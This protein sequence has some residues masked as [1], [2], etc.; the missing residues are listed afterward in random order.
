MSRPIRFRAWDSK[1]KEWLTYF[2]L[3][4]S[5]G[6]VIQASHSSMKPMEGRVHT[7]Y[8]DYIVSQ[9]T[10]LTDRNGKEI[11]EGD[12]I[13]EADPKYRMDD[14]KWLWLV[15]WTEEHACFNVCTIDRENFKKSDGSPQG[16]FISLCEKNDDCEVLSNVH[17]HPELLLPKDEVG[18]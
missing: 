10:G 3:D 12:I 17:E 13:R 5:N 9:F 16:T 1:N 2:T 6:Q 15:E 18:L 11:W 4:C 8:R 7:D 14:G